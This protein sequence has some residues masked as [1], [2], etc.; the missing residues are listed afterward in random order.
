[1]KNEFLVATRQAMYGLR[2]RQDAHQRMRERA[3][4]RLR[5]AQERHTLEIGRAEMM[6]AKGWMELLS[7]SGVT[8]P[9]AAALLQVS[10]ST[11]SRWLA[12]YN[13]GVEEDAASAGGGGA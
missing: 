13:R 4:S 2:D 12:R 8:I 1:M 11:V 6:E 7:V 10:E 9:T 3:D 5:L